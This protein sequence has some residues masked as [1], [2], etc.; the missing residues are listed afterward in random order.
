M[1][2][3]TT[4]EADGGAVSFVSDELTPLSVIE[5]RTKAEGLF[6]K[7]RAE[8]DAH[9]PD[10]TTE[11][12]R[13]AIKSLAFK[14]TKTKTAVDDARKK[15]TEDARKQ[16]DAA[17]AAGRV[18]WDRLEDLAAEARKPLTEWEQ[19][20]K[21]RV[22]TVA[23]RFG[24]IEQLG[25][26]Q[27]EDTT[28][29][30]AERMA[31]LEAMEFEPAVFGDS[32]ERAASAKGDALHAL[33]TLQA[34]LTMEEADRAELARLRQES[35]AR[36][37]QDRL[38]QEAEALKAKEAADAQAEKD[39]AAEVERQAQERATQTIAKAEEDRKAEE[40]RVADEATAREN[41]RAHRAKIMGAIKVAI[42]AVGGIDNDAATKIVLA[43]AK[44]T[45]PN[46]H[47]DF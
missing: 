37:E 18:I 14:V 40:K 23:A 27:A 2:A 20:E 34:R 9:V 32:L 31:T 3:M 11:K 19:A 25:R 35:A 44:R 28:A 33:A 45:V 13:K 21:D 22:A 5:D 41:D 1:N 6:A 46:I 17:N 12:G 10:L 39:R 36:D 43:V 15:L 24:L 42:M 26:A 47:I 38:A 16:V 7:V 8:I 4:I 30:V 29:A